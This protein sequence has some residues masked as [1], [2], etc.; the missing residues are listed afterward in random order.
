MTVSP[1]ADRAQLDR[2]VAA[3]KRAFPRW[4]ATPIRQRGALL[5]KL[6]DALESE[7]N[8]MVA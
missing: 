4:S 2:A 7:Q 6:A 5:A 3:A 8:G 1:R